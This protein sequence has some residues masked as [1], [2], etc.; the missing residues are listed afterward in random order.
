MTYREE[1]L[2]AINT[3]VDLCVYHNGEQCT[4][5]EAYALCKCAKPIEL[6][7]NDISKD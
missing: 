7:T 1:V 6:L 5:C 2:A 3:L 4:E